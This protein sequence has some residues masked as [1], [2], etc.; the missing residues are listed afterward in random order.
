VGRILLIGKTGQVGHELERTLQP[1]GELIAPDRNALDL[2]N[3][4][5]IRNIIRESRP[6]AIVNAAGFTIVDDAESR[7]ELAMQ[8]NGVAP[9]IIAECAAGSGALMIHFSTT[10]VFDGTKHEP[11]TEDDAPNPLNAYGRSKLAGE[12]AVMSACPRH[13]ILRA[14]WVYS[15]RRSNFV[16][17]ILKLARRD[18]EITIVDDQFGSPTWAGDYAEATARMLRTP[19]RIVDNPGIYHLSARSSC[20]RM[21]WAKTIIDAAKAVRDDISWASLRPTSSASYP[22][23]APRPLHTVT[24]NRKIER[25]LGITLPAWEDRVDSFVR[26]LLANDHTAPRNSNLK[27]PAT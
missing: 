11:Y 21:Q 16:L 9:G 24:S 14:N 27:D 8:L 5:S 20:S 15:A 6:E 19:E 17:A 26:A 13:L 10:F 7:P 18:N 22:H 23:A 1:L 3:P 12:Q 2:T 4:D 25:N